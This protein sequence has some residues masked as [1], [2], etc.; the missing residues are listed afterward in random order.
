MLAN[1]DA[2][3]ALTRLCKCNLAQGNVMVVHFGVIHV[4]LLISFSCDFR[5]RFSQTWR[6]RIFHVVGQSFFSRQD[7]V[8]PWPRLT[9]LV[10]DV[11]GCPPLKANIRFKQS[12]RVGFAG[13][14]IQRESTT[15]L[16]NVL[17]AASCVALASRID[18][19]RFFL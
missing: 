16:R 18:V 19:R 2:S 15:R 12:G 11:R 17:A 4:Q 9:L 1:D 7:C 10:E 13:S 6:S 8:A 3:V 14:G 5:C